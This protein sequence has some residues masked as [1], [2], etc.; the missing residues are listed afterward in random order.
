MHIAKDVVIE[1]KESSIRYI[2]RSVDKEINHAFFIFISKYSLEGISINNNEYYFFNNFIYVSYKHK[3]ES[4]YSVSQISE[5]MHKFG[6]KKEDISY[7]ISRYIDGMYF[8]A[9]L[10]K[11][12][13]FIL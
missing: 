10:N 2:K 13:G 5:K 9:F 4:R 12:S 6:M 3:R 7:Y 8:M 1:L 11:D